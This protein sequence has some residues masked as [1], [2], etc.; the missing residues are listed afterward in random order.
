MNKAW[1][2]TSRQRLF[3]PISRLLFGV[4]ME[5]YNVVRVSQERF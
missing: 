1:N 2:G 5:R 4:T 3:V